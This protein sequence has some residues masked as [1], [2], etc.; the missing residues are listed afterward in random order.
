MSAG[1]PGIVASQSVTGVRADGDGPALVAEVGLVFGIVAGIGRGI[2]ATDDFG[3]SP[4]LQGKSL[5]PVR[6]DRLRLCKDGK[7]R[8][9][10]HNRLDSRTHG[11]CES[12][13]LNDR[14]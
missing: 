9:T 12:W 1:L 14:I 10:Q 6:G 8:R 11:F 7:S 5:K 4:F 3:D 2:H 13:L